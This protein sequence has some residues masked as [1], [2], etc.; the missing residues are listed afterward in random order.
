MGVLVAGQRPAAHHGGTTLVRSVRRGT[1]VLHG[2]S[3][4]AQRSFTRE[5]SSR[6]AAA[7]APRSIS[8]A[9]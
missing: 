3:T 6:K 9:C 8:T 4:E 2:I 1:K 7:A 5:P